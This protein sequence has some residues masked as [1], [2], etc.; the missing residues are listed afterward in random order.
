MREQINPVQR[1][2][3]Y[4]RDSRA[5]LKDWRKT[6]PQ[7]RSACYYDGESVDI[8]DRQS[9]KTDKHERVPTPSI[10]QMSVKKRNR[11]PRH[12]ARDTR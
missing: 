9:A 12:A 2:R 3:G 10:D 8:E 5:V 4:D 7:S 6:D 11:G 1:E